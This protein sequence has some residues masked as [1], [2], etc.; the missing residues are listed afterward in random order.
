MRRK[1]I[2][3]GVFSAFYAM[4]ELGMQWNPSADPLSPQW[5]KEIFSPT[6]S[7]YFYRVIYDIIFL[8]PSWLASG[9]LVSFSTLWY[10]VYTSTLEDVL[11]WTIAFEKP[12]SWAWFYPVLGG[13]PIDDL[14]ACVFLL[15]TYNLMKVK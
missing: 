1:L 13:I 10:F 7:L 14:I 3:L 6:V 9:K 4:L 12:Y 5:M 2:T 8:Y 11:Y 15:M